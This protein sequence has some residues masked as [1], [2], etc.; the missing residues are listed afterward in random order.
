MSRTPEVLPHGM[1]FATFPPG[2][3]ERQEPGCVT[4]GGCFFGAFG[5]WAIALAEHSF[6]VLRI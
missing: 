5:T 3:Q 6:N 2:V 4:S 1:G